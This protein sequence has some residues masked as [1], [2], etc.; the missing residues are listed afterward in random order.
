M[1]IVT[2]STKMDN[3]NNHVIM[4]DSNN[5]N[6]KDVTIIYNMIMI[7]TMMTMTIIMIVNRRRNSTRTSTS[8]GTSNSTSLMINHNNSNNYDSIEDINHNNTNDN[9]TSVTTTREIISKSQQVPMTT[10]ESFEQYYSFNNK[11]T[12]IL[13][14]MI[15]ERKSVAD[16]R[17]YLNS[18]SKIVSSTISTTVTTKEITRLET[19]TMNETTKT[20]TPMESSSCLF[21]TTN[22]TTANTI[23]EEKEGE[24][25]NINHHND[26]H[27][28]YDA[29]MT[30]VTD[31]ILNIDDIKI[32][33]AP[34]KALNDNT[35]FDAYIEYTTK[36]N[37]KVAIGIEVKYT[38]RSYKYGDT[39]HDS[40]FDE[41]GESKYLTPT[42]NCPFYVAGASLRLREKKLKQP[43]RNHLLG[44]VLSIGEKKIYD[45]F[46]SM[47]LYPSINTYQEDVCV[48]YMH[49]LTEEGKKYFIPLTYEK[50]IS[51][52]DK[53]NID[54]DWVKYFK[55][56]YLITKK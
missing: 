36:F 55:E 40:M 41:T 1:S 5:N 51:D 19:T 31:T 2:S 46:Y 20:L 13:F 33:H 24:L 34:M 30:T 21:E 38:E 16:I 12:L 54:E 42:K 52:C 35:S 3:N 37:K 49:E 9:D 22:M 28:E 10:T 32:E 43:W 17:Q 47:H 23:T 14:R 6:S 7:I 50:M 53:A 48:N 15:H 29:T 11:S 56:R 27:D 4:I 45:E 25:T 26:S 8:N 44:I 18:F 39:E